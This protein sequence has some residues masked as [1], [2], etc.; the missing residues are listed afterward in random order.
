MAQIEFLGTGTSTGVPQPLCTCE[1]CR[2]T[3]P[4]DKR[5]RCSSLLKF[6]NTNILIDCSPDFRQQAMRANIDHIDALLLTHGHADHMGGIDDLRP[7][8]TYNPLPIYAEE[9]VIDD[10]K[11][12]LPYCFMQNP[13]PG[14][15]RLDTYPIVANQ[16]FEVGNITI[17]PL[18]VMHFNLP[19]V[20]FRINNMAY[21]TDCLTMP[22]E[23]IPQ[24][25]GL[26]LLVINA[27]RH[28]EHISH[29][30]LSD[31]L[32][33][34]ERLAPQRAYLIHMSHDMGLHAK[35]SQQLPPHV[36][37]AYDGLK[38]DF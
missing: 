7:Y 37:F 30:T 36:Q 12:R 33:L 14:I 13:Y 11:R 10:V 4:R 19:I 29:Q 16:P 3:D 1:V 31:A 24:L 35:V 2:S 9:R 5:L 23:T 17:T 22:Q 21:V 18:R 32:A 34:I 28:T 8:C 38:L 26:D 25:Q 15:P 6:D 27:L 20:A